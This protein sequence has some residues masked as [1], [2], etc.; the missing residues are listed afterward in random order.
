MEM[1]NVS[2][3]GNTE[4]YLIQGAE[5]NPHL[6]SPLLEQIGAMYNE[7]AP[8]FVV[9]QGLYYPAAT[10]Y[11]Y[12]CTG[13]ESPGE[14]EDHQRIFGVDS[15]DIQ[16]AGAQ[17]ESSPYVYYTP[18]YGYAQSPYNPYNPYI[19]GA[20][21]GVESQ[22]VG[23]QQYY[24]IPPYQNPVS[25]PAYVPFFVQQ[26]IVPSTSAEPLYDTGASM[27]RPEGRGLKQNFSSATGA[28]PRNSLKSVP[29]QTSSLARVSEGPRAHVG[30][31][32]Q[33]TIYGSAAGS[34][35]SPVSTNVLQS[36]NASGSVP[37]VDNISNGKVLSHQNQL[38]VTLPIGN[39]L[40]G[41]G[42]SAYGQ[43]GGA[44]IR[45]K[46]HVG[47]AMNE[48]IGSP[49]ALGEQNRG[50]RINRSKNQLAVKAY[51][52]R[53]GEHVQ[54]NIIISTDQYNKD[55]FPIDYVDAKFFVIKSYSEDDVHKSI[56]YNVWSS[57]PHG[58]KKLDTAYEDAQRI[59][60]GKTRSCPIFLFFSVNASGQFC[61]VAEMVGPVDFNKD[62]DFWQQDKWS[63]SFPV[64]WHIIKDVPNT[65]FRH[66][67]LENNENKPVTNSRDT[68]EIMHKKGQEMMKI[69][70]SF[71]LKTSLLDDFMY[72]ETRQKIMQEEKARLLVKSFDGPYFVPAL[73]PPRKLNSV[74]E[75][76]PSEDENITKPNDGP[77][78]SIK[79][80]VFAPKQV[81]YN[82]DVTNT[83]IEHGNAEQIAVE[84]KNDVVSTLKI[85]S[86]TISPKQA[87]PKPF[88][89]AGMAN[90]ESVDVVTVGS[91]PIKVNG[92]AESGFLTVGTIPLDP[93]A[94]QLDKGIGSV[95]NGS[96]R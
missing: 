90:T 50:P 3:H 30:P 23:A 95:N 71:T 11:G 32:K 19:P 48:A 27:N 65:N 38:K 34:F 4:T 63:G 21:I 87:E 31:S 24:T 61:G 49:D 54:G 13:F 81:S 7:G 14:W 67:I 91:V 45:P 52:N 76:P 96:Q 17:N 78:S 15:P 28:L 94:L 9:D 5:S 39:G 84:A 79:I 10:N 73:D 40:S 58:N 69:F 74:L 56:K 1:Y 85:G 22:F 62:M 51:T 47:R 82:S 75:L 35:P 37:A 66:I 44:K 92:F 53:A 68:Q 93:R 64:K 88:P 25:P 33:S 8:E 57:T 26:D 6:T 55:E 43:A 46:I 59:G 86:V 20:M 18:G 29:N 60:A 42:S 12:Y 83:S 80:G 77:K 72:Y 36:R 70:K 41:F 89:A 2:E 16:Y